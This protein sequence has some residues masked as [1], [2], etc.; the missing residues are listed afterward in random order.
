MFSFFLGLGVKLL[1]PR[2][3]VCLARLFFQRGCTISHSH[4]HFTR[5]LVAPHP[6]QPVWLLNYLTLFQ[7]LSFVND[8]KKSVSYFYY[9]P[10]KQL[11]FLISQ[12]YSFFS[13]YFLVLFIFFFQLFIL[14]YIQ[15]Q[16]VA[17]GHCPSFKFLI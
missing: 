10:R 4:Q 8:W 17:L 7:P 9:F 3:N 15:T 12:S 2:I 14:T 6:H 5:V 11:K 13:Y 1:G 16:K